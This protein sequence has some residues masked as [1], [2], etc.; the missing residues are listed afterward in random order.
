ML[1]SLQIKATPVPH[2]SVFTMPGWIPV[3]IHENIGDLV[4]PLI[5]IDQQGIQV[6]VFGLVLLD[7]DD[8]RCIH[9]L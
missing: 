5:R 2:R 7:N 6:Q 8:R 4:L 1:G 3:D 9:Q